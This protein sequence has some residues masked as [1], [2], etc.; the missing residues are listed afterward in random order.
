MLRKRDV[1]A[2]LTFYRK[3]AQVFIEEVADWARAVIS[4]DMRLGRYVANI[5][6]PKEAGKVPLPISLGRESGC[7]RRK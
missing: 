5:L 3:L 6:I 2:I 1:T 4:L 7:I